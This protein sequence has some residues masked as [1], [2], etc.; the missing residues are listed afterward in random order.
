M[1]KLITAAIAISCLSTGC[2]ERPTAHAAIATI[3]IG[4]ENVSAA[5]LNT[6]S[7]SGADRILRRFRMATRAACDVQFGARSDA[8][9]A[10]E[11]SC[12]DQTMAR[13]VS[14]LGSHTVSVRHA[15]DIAEQRN[16]VT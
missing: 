16:F 11:Q 12:V 4:A 7:N 6:S 15:R 8:E 5:G 13:A 3:S 2:A 9:M 14:D 10:R 1:F